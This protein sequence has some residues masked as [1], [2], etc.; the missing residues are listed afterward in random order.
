[1]N[2]ILLLGKIQ[3]VSDEEGEKEKKQYIT[4]LKNNE[5]YS[6]VEEPDLVYNII[7]NDSHDD[8]SDDSISVFGDIVEVE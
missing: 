1:M 3:L 4:K 8:A 7:E 5:K 2:M 6:Y